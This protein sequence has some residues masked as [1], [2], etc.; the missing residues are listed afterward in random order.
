MKNYL[1]GIFFLTNLTLFSQV[2]LE[3][4]FMIDLNS[5][6]EAYNQGDWD[7]VS[8]MWNP[9]LFEIAPKEQLIGV[10]EMMSQMGMNMKINILGIEKISNIIRHEDSD[11]CRIDYKANTVIELSGDMLA[12]IEELK[13]NFIRIHGQ[14][15][16][17]FDEN[18]IYINAIQSMI[19]VKF[20]K[21]WKY[22]EISKE[23]TQAIEMIIPEKVFNQL[24]K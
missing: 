7:T 3:K 24:N 13:Q 17:K 20:E 21:E 2:D 18:T 11:Y 9:K 23:N 1:L 6:T 8:S 4:N 14:D 10:F 5:Y 15:S 12:A 22:S 19:A 16:V